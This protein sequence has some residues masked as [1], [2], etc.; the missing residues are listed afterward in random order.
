MRIR[1]RTAK[2]LMRQDQAE[3]MKAR[4]GEESHPQIAPIRAD[5]KKN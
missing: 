4:K 3:E 2:A 1:T 5:E